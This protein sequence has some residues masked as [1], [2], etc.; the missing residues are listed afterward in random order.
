MN[1][2]DKT[3]QAIQILRQAIEKESMLTPHLYK[4]YLINDDFTPMDF[5][6]DILM[7]LFHFERDLAIKLMLQVHYHG[8]A[9]CGLF[10]RE[11]AET[12]VRQVCFLARQYEHPLLCEFEPA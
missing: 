7:Q 12:K 4:V 1:P 8:K 9:M 11:I 2:L 5:V 10:S 6:V 3:E